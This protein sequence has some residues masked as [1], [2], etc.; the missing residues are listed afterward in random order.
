V[1]VGDRQAAGAAAGAAPRHR[2]AAD[3]AVAAHLGHV[4]AEADRLHAD[5]V[6]FAAVLEAGD[7]ERAQDLYAASRWHLETIEPVAE[8]YADLHAAIDAHEGDGPAAEWTGWHRIERAL[9]HDGTAAGLGP[10]ADRLVADVGALR[11]R[12]ETLTLGPAEIA[13]GAVALLHGASTESI[14][15]EEERYAR[16]DLSNLAANVEG[17]SAAFGAVRPLLAK[18]DADLAR[19]VDARFADLR[20]ALAAHADAGDPV[21]HGYRRHD[22]LTDEDTRALA[23][24]VDALAEP[25]SRVAAEIAG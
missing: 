25:L 22:D 15:G 14:T 16:T 19:E 11:A 24:V 6:A 7:R 1:A 12:I 2:E 8:R 18:T 20:A 23:A 13:T 10:L 3:L 17:A 9:F 5:V 4:R 21:G